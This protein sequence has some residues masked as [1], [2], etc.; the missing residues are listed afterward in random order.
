MKI[1]DSHWYAPAALCLAA[2]WLLVLVAPITAQDSLPT[3]EDSLGT[4]MASGSEEPAASTS[5]TAPVV[6]GEKPG[7]RTPPGPIDFML[8][9]KFLGFAVLMILGLVVLFRRWSRL[10]VRI[11]LLLVAFVLFGLDYFY[12]LH[13][14]PLCAVTKLFMFKFT[15]GEFFP[16]FVALFL[17]MMIPSLIGRKL[18]CGWVCPLGAFQDLINKIPFKPRFKRFNFTLFNTARMVLLAAFIFTFFGVKDHIEFLGGQVG[19]GDAENTWT[20]FASYSLYDPINFFELLHWSMN[21]VR[22]FVLLALI[23]LFSLILYRPFCY[24]ICPIGA[25]TWLLEKVA[26]GRIRID[27]EK[28][29]MCE[30]CYEASP[31][32]T[33]MPLVEQNMKTLPDCTS[34]GECAPVCPEDAISFKFKK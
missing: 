13:P 14:S 5:E 20:A 30:D 25:L 4:H 19:L 18:F 11:T 6:E 15:W 3:P 33:I 7:E 9:G 34:C 31:C 23:V 17:A 2:V 24:L 1:K 22:W 26:P 10:W 8:T 21:S 29:T 32:P 16:A 12:P 27:H 28:C